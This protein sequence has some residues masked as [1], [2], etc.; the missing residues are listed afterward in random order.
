MISINIVM[1][2]ILFI[3][4]EGFGYLFMKK[5]LL[6]ILRICFFIYFIFIFYVVNYWIVNKIDKFLIINLIMNF[7]LKYYY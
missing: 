4:K 3:L 2:I 5:N 1:Y 7:R 6:L